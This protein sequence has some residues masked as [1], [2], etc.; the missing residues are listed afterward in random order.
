MTAQGFTS[1]GSYAP[2]NL[3]GGEFPR[4]ARKITVATGANLVAGSLL[5]KITASGKHILSL[6]AAEDGSQTPDVILAEAADAASADVQAVAYF[7]GE[8]NELAV[9]FGT[10]HTANSVREALRDKSIFL[11]QNQG[12]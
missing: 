4:V 9:T 6:S 5:G 10:G 3:I 8:F 11:T 12:A 1:H 7:S 2:E